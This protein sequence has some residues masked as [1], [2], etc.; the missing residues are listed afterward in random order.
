[1]GFNFSMGDY[2]S[3]RARRHTKILADACDCHAPGKGI[4]LARWIYLLPGPTFYEPGNNSF[5]TD[6][7]QTAQALQREK[8]APV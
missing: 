5:D 4:M 6:A 8:S 2:L 3:N 7:A 1:M